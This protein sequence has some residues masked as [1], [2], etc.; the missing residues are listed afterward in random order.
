MDHQKDFIEGLLEEIK[1]KN[2]DLS[3]ETLS[4]IRLGYSMAYGAGAREMMA[5]RSNRKAVLK[6]DKYGHVMAE[7]PSAAQAARK[8][9]LNR[10]NIANV[11][12]GRYGAKTAGG[13][14]WKWK[15]RSA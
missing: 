13:H 4:D 14:K 2:P 10:A 1:D 15:E 12:N 3:R 5:L 6:F 11:C 7:Y 9:K 8:N